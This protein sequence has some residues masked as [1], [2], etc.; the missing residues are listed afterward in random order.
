MSV[1]RAISPDIA[2]SRPLGDR[3]SPLKILEDL[4][5][6][7]GFYLGN[8]LMCIADCASGGHHEHLTK[9]LFYLRYLRGNERLIELLADHP[10][11]GL[12][13]MD[14]QTVAQRLEVTDPALISAVAM[15]CTVSR[16]QLDR[17]QCERILNYAI[18]ALECYA[19]KTRRCL[20]S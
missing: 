3:S 12:K 1:L 9:A 14:S 7:P 20:R 2:I 19:K 6:G 10:C 17:T 5:F 8:A 16:Y 15:L 13:N 4:G 11:A 18:T